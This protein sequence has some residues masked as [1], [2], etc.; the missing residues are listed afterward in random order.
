MPRLSQDCYAG[1]KPPLQAVIIFTEFGLFWY[2]FKC[3]KH[4]I[5]KLDK[6]TKDMRQ[7]ILKTKLTE[8]IKLWH[9]WWRHIITFIKSF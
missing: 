7:I 9:S 5:T 3:I 1:A 2:N 6:L 8:D 4:F